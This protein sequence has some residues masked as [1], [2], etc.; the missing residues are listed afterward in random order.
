MTSEYRCVYS[1]KPSKLDQN[2]KDLIT[3]RVSKII[4][5]SSKLNS[6]VYRFEIKA[7]RLY[8]YHLYEQH[9]WDDSNKTFIKPLIDGRYKE[10]PL[11]R[12][13]IINSNCSKCRLDW[14]RSNGQWMDLME[15]NLEECLKFIEEDDWFSNYFFK[16]I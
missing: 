8:L 11:A 3:D 13:M 10:F 4:K 2:K 1:P 14:Q 9:G 16:E 12:I 5:N 7:G 6:V 15:G